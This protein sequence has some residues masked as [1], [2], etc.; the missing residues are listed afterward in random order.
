MFDLL[1]AVPGRIVVRL[2]GSHLH[3]Q[4]TEGWHT[5]TADAAPFRLKPFGAEM[6]TQDRPGLPA[7]KTCLRTAALA[8]RK[9]AGIPGSAF[10]P[11]F[12]ALPIPPGAVLA[13]YWPIG[14]EADVRPLLDAWTARGFPAALPLVAAKDAPLL[15]RRWRPGMTLE[16]GPH[17]TFHP[18]ASAG[19]VEPRVLLVPLLAFDG[20]GGR[21]GYGGG[22]YDR[23]LAALRGAG[24]QVL[25]VGVAFAAQEVLDLPMENHDQRLDW[26]ITERGALER[27]R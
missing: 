1:G 15:F 25:A 26:L 19:E 12:A 27:L 24:K 22:Y 6:T 8:R 5:P 11:A 4:A 16:A 7:D 2:H 10:L 14:D 21:L 23:T 13:G 18:P 3:L 20:R 9:G 17:K